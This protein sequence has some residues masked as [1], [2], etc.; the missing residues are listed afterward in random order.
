MTLPI[1]APS[2]YQSTAYTNEV[3]RSPLVLAAS[4]NLNRARV[5]IT[6]C[7]DTLRIFSSNMDFSDMYSD[8]WKTLVSLTSHSSNLDVEL[9]DIF[10]WVIHRS[11]RDIKDS[12]NEKLFVTLMNFTAMAGMEESHNSLLSISDI[13]ID[14][15]IGSCGYTCLLL[16][17]SLFSRVISEFAGRALDITL[18]SGANTHL[19]GLDEGCSPQEE[20]PTSLAMYSSFVF[21]QWR[22]ALLRLSVDLETFVAEELQQSPLRDAGW[23]EDTLLSL[24]R[25]DIQPGFIPLEYDYPCGICGDDFGIFAELSWRRWLDS[26]KHASK[27]EEDCNDE[28]RNDKQANNTIMDKV[29][30]P[31]SEVELSNSSVASD[32]EEETTV[33]TDDL[34][35]SDTDDEGSDVG[36]DGEVNIVCIQCYYKYGYSE[37]DLEEV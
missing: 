32:E 3:N 33:K 30:Y 10:R 7:I 12:I 34:D 27:F 2:P 11:A 29:R 35:E 25:G 9:N 1:F 6:D 5:N 4:P 23:N 24:F 31:A 8:G 16:H 21:I 26:I 37:S 14:A 28:S 15:R 36:S 19:V 22:D 13:G 18:R 20:T 17:L